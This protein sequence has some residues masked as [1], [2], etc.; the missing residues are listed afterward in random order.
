MWNLKN[1]R[2]EQI[3]QKQTL[4]YRKQ[5]LGYQSRSVLVEAGEVGAED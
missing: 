1:E 5:I 3:K 4:R 2:N